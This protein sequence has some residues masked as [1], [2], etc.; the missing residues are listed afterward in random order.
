MKNV[1]NY[2]VSKNIT[3]TEKNNRAKVIKFSESLNL[4]KWHLNSI[5]LSNLQEMRLLKKH[6]Y[7][8]RMITLYLKVSNLINILTV[9]VSECRKQI[10]CVSILNSELDYQNSD[11]SW[12]SSYYIS[13]HLSITCWKWDKNLINM[14]KFLSELVCYNLK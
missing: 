7:K 3:Q 14:K 10:D 5:K 1:L 12:I 9:F 4:F 13:I 6:W 8:I 2:H 11:S